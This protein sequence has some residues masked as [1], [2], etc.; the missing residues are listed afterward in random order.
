[1]WGCL[2]LLLTL[3]AD[4]MRMIRGWVDGSFAVHP[5]MKSHTG[6]IMSL[7]KGT[8]YAPSKWQKMNTQS[9]TEAELVA[10]DDV[11]AQVMWTRY[12]LE[13]QGHEVKENIIYQDNQ[14]AMLLQKKGRKTIGRRT[15]HISIRYF[16]V[17][18]QIKLNEVSIEYCPTK[19]MTEDFMTKPLQGSPFKNFRAEILNL[20][21]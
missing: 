16:F 7:G 18:D 11:M 13:G 20:Q 3:E 9:S 1:M 15:R 4:D 8:Q 17:T 19:E 14:S 5:N 2:D 10:V 6:A 12:F 21:V